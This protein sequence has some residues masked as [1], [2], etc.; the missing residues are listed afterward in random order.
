MESH[1]MLIKIIHYTVFSAVLISFVCFVLSSVDQSRFVALEKLW[2]YLTSVVSG[3][4]FRWSLV[5][6]RFGKP[7]NSEIRGLYWWIWNYQLLHII[8][9]TDWPVLIPDDGLL[10]SNQV[11]CGDCGACTRTSCHP[12]FSNVIVVS[13]Q[14]ERNIQLF[15]TSGKP[16]TIKFSWIY[17]F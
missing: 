12:H 2:I 5:I 8:F 1:L 6:T 16:L 17:S 7:G 14:P 10:T 4:V 9:C 13:V 11:L 15:P 3:S